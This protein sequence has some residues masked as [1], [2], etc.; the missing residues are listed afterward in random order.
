MASDKDENQVSRVAKL[1]RTNYHEWEDDIKMI[2]IIKG[3]WRTLQCEKPPRDNLEALQYWYWSEIQEQSLAVIHL[4]C[5][6]DQQ[7][8]ISEC[9]TGYEAWET[10]A[11]TYAS[12]DIANVMR[13]EELFGRA[14]NKQ[15]CSRTRDSSLILALAAI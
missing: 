8:L 3:F 13:I 10:L 1:N 14:N 7:H 2:L 12:N 4:S 6:R 11:D 5:E 15:W 9:K